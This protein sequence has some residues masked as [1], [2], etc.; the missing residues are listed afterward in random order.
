MQKSLFLYKK[1]MTV[2]SEHKKEAPEG[3]SAKFRHNEKHKRAAY[4]SCFVLLNT[5][6]YRI[7]T[8]T[9]IS[10]AAALRI[11]AIIAC[12]DANSGIPPQTVRITDKTDTA[13]TGF[14]IALLFAYN[15]V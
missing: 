4:C 13:I 7:T 2:L 12:C 5:V 14:I 1:I 8:T 3:A 9:F 10:D 15:C 11:I 6:I